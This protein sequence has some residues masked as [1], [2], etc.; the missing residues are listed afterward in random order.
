MGAMEE[1]SLG[2]AAD[3]PDD[4]KTILAR[5]YMALHKNGV[6]RQ[7]FIASLKSAGYSVDPSTLERWIVKTDSTGS[8]ISKDK[9]SGSEPWLS[10]EQRNVNGSS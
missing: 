4:F 6:S 5:L 10:R 9:E 1:L 8:A 7:L 3:I 2:T